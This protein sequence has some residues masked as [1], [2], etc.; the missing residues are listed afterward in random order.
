MAIEADRWHL[1]R[2]DLDDYYH[3]LEDLLEAT[4]VNYLEAMMDSAPHAQVALEFSEKLP[5]LMDLYDR[6]V[7][8]RDV[9]DA[10]RAHLT[11]TSANGIAVPN[12]PFFNSVLSPMN[13]REFVGNIDGLKLRLREQIAA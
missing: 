8:N 10:L 4:A 9:L 2:R 13:W 12:P 1:I 6:A 11:I 3:A 7:K 5:S